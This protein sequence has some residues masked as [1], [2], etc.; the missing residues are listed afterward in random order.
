MKLCLAGADLR[1]G[2]VVLVLVALVVG[3]GGL[4][5]GRPR[6]ATGLEVGGMVVEGFETWSLGVC[7]EK[8]QRLR[9][10]VAEG[11][12]ECRGEVFTH[13]QLMANRPP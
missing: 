11:G 6:L 2:V 13:V 3:R 1:R 9:S 4:N 10:R 5:A 12:G 8:E 7:L